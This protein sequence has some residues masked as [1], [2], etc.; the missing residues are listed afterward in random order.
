MMEKLVIAVQDS[1]GGYEVINHLQSLVSGPATGAVTEAGGVA[2]G[3]AG[4][5][6]A[7]GDLYADDLDGNDDAFQAV[8]AGAA[9]ANHYG[10]YSVAANGVWTYT[11]DNSNAAVQALND[12]SAPL[13]DSFTVLSEDGTAKSSRS[14]STVPMTR[15]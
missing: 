9:T 13:T 3:I 1:S 11:L 7:T 2:N 6:T 4:T 8:A 5:P 10:T 15:R 14:L 12:S